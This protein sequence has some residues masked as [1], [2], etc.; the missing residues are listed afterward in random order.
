[1]T[2]RRPEERRERVRYRR[3]RSPSQAV[4]EL[5]RRL[6]N[7]LLWHADDSKSGKS[8]GRFLSSVAVGFESVSLEQIGGNV[9]LIFIAKHESR[10]VAEFRYS[11]GDRFSSRKLRH[12]NSAVLATPPIS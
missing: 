8:Q 9:F 12:A 1:V 2:S 5:A 4:R 6:G 10:S 3:S 7:C 11:S